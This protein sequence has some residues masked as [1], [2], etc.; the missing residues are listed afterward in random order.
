MLIVNFKSRQVP[1]L[2]QDLASES[3]GD[4]L[5]NSSFLFFGFPTGLAYISLPIRLKV[6]WS[7]VNENASYEN[8]SGNCLRWGLQETGFEMETECRSFTGECFPWRSKGGRIGQWKEFGSAVI[9]KASAN[10]T[11]TLGLDGPAELSW[12]EVSRPDS[13]TFTLPC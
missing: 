2:T 11:V 4:R 7:F 1:C 12:N 3:L 5:K 9:K 13:G 6:V 10:P 8:A